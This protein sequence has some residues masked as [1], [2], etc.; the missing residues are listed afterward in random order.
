MNNTFH[1]QPKYT[2][3][4][5]VNGGGVNAFYSSVNSDKIE[6]L[7]LAQTYYILYMG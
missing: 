1:I 6:V 7:R 3:L 5:K 2:L 4:T